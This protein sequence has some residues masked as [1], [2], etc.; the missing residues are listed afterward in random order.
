MSYVTTPIILLSYFL[1]PSQSSKA[2]AIVFLDLGNSLPMD[3]HPIGV[4]LFFLN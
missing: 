4:S 2:L 1:V 3:F